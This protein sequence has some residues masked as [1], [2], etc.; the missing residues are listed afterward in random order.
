MEKK[1]LKI[2][3]PKTTNKDT[4]NESATCNSEVV[5][6][7]A[8]LA[9]LH[10]EPEALACYVADM[11]SIVHFAGQ[12]SSLDCSGVAAMTS[13]LERGRW[14]KDERTD[15]GYPKLVVKNAPKRYGNFFS[16]PKVK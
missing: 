4:T 16:V 13:T 9:R 7:M 6:K 11:S 1:N 2:T 10:I 12:I 15:G 3:N 5:N 8:H 14:R